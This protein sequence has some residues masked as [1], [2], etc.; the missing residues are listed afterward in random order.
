MNIFPTAS[1]ARTGSRNNIAIMNEVRA[2]EMAILQEI[3]NGNF[4]VDIGTGTTVG[5]VT[6]GYVSP[7]TDP[8]NGGNSNPVI[9]SQ[10]YYSVIFGTLDNRSLREQVE[11]VKRNFKDLG[12]QVTILVNASTGNTFFWRIF[13]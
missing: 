10:M 8:L 13:W 12:Y 11:M 9:S 1:E 3:E 5:G 4:N 2:I 6:T 7:M